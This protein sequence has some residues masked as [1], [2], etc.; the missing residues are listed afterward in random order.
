MLPKELLDVRRVKGRIMPKFAGKEDYELAEKI[1]ALFRAGVGKKY[2]IIAAKLKEL[3]N[4]KNFRKMR[5]LMRVLENYCVEKACIFGVDSEIE[6][7]RVRM[8]LFERGFVTSKKERDRVIEYAA[9]YFRTTPET[10]ERA[11]YA[12]REEELILSHFRPINPDEL[13]KLYNLSLLQT[14]LFNALRLKF[15]VSSNH[16]QIFSAI[17]RLGLMYELYEENGKMVVEVT[18]AASMLKMTRKYGTSFA[19]LIPY[20]I[21]AENW[22]MQ[23]EIVEGDRLYIMELDDR[24]RDIFPQKEEKIDYDSSL[25]EE[26][27]R[28]MRMLGY[29][30][31]REP[32]IIK[33]GRYAFIP[34]FAIDIGDSRVYVEIAGF[35]T[36]EYLKK[37]VEKIKSSNIPLI[38]LAREDFGDRAGLSEV[39]LFS[40]R[41]PY[42]EV[43]RALKKY[44]RA[45]IRGDVV[46]IESLESFDIPEDYV[47]AGKY[48]LRRELFEKIK[49]EFTLCNP[50]TLEE[51]KSLLEK[52]GL[53]ESVLT[54]LGYRV[55]WMGLGEAVLERCDD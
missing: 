3:E 50:K 46:E 15:W 5:G 47:L 38:V 41:I 34:D 35:W 16:K 19:K 52:Y 45:E 43:I 39:I 40:S 12:D 49:D 18:G 37:K 53:G 11:M 30:V 21:R 24:M 28:K 55:K 17:K 48:I 8:L 29:K 10:I 31:E 51:A 1:V 32:D 14:A 22:Y 33:A 9:R 44:K 7:Y 4:A 6:P 13:L 25:E 23:A 42:G 27:A 36:E 54:A 20:I 2:G 26:F